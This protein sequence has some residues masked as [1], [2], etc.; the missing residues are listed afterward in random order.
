M[1]VNG[2]DIWNRTRSRA[3]AVYAELGRFVELG[4]A[5]VEAPRQD[6]YGIVVNT[7]TVG[8]HGEDPFEHLPLDATRFSAEQIVVDMVYGPQPSLL[9][10]AAAKAG[11]ATVDGV[12]VLVQQGA[13]SLQIWTGREPPLDAMRAAA[14]P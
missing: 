6:D 11:A 13:L 2:V 8:L 12:E 9:L 5:P 14:R 7:T 3:N 1:D 4:G 10:R